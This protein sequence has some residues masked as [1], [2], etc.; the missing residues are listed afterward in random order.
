[1]SAGTLQGLL[2]GDKTT[3]DVVRLSLMSRGFCFLN[4]P[5]DLTSLANDAKNSLQQLFSLPD[6]HKQQLNVSTSFGYY[7]STGK[8]GFRVPSGNKTSQLEGLMKDPSLSP[9]FS[10]T[11]KIDK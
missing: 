3:Y 1:M 6:F 7:S 8:E 2:G 9:L 11:H 4:L 10:L 5:S